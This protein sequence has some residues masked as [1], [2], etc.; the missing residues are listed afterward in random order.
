[1]QLCVDS[2]SWDSKEF[3]RAFRHRLGFAKPVD[4][5]PKKMI[6][7]MRWKL[8]MC[9]KCEINAKNLA[10]LMVAGACL[11]RE[12]YKFRKKRKRV[13]PKENEQ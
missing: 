5:V 1:M 2:I 10:G 13:K 3:S 4:F 7:K 9:K 8:E 11:R 6:R 12:Y